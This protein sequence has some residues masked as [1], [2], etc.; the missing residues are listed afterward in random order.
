MVPLTATVPEWTT[1]G[2]LPNALPPGPLPSAVLLTG[3]GGSPSALLQ[4]G[5][6][7]NARAEQ[8]VREFAIAVAD[9]TAVPP[10]MSAHEALANGVPVVVIHD[11]HIVGVV[12]IDEVRRAAG[13]DVVNV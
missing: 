12:G 13:R 4:T 11:G 5:A 1:V 6:L 2:E 3:F 9:V 8:R 10:T 7:R